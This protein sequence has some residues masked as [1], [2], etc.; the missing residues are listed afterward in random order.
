MVQYLIVQ[1][2]VGVGLAGVRNEPTHGMLRVC[3]S[4]SPRKTHRERAVVATVVLRIL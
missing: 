3:S 1:I 2:G 4:P